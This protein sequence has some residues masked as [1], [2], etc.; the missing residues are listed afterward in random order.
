[1]I[2]FF[3]LVLKIFV[4]NEQ[5]DI[6]SLIFVVVVTIKLKAPEVFSLIIKKYMYTLQIDIYKVIFQLNVL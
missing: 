6:F 5:H 3:I 2:H 1:M 4:Y